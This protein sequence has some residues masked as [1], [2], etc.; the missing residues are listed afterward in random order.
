[1][2]NRGVLTAFFLMAAFATAAS[3]PPSND[4]VEQALL[5]SPEYT[6]PLRTSGDGPFAL[7][8]DVDRDGLEDVMLIMAVSY[9]HLRAH[10]T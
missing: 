10:E 3:D 7:V 4:L 9:T 8:R 5:Y 2:R 6:R 1:M